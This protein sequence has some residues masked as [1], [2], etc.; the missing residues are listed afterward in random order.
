MKSKFKYPKLALL[1]IVIVLTYILFRTTEIGNFISNLGVLKGLGIFIVGI[2]YPFSF[3]S[4]LS[5][6]FF[7]TVDNG[8]IFLTSLIGGLGG[9][10]SDL[11]LFRFVRISFTDEFY[12]LKNEQIIKKLRNWARKK[13]HKHVRTILLHLFTFFLIASP[14]PD[15]AGIVLLSGFTKIKMKTIALITLV[16][17]TIGIVIILLIGKAI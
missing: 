1:G 13:M 15:E 6:A 10:V 5:A 11:I 2:L 3:T 12:K 16:C 4:P 17:H 7:L 8:N 14:L 9:M